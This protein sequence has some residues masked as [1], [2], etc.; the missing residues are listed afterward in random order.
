MNPFY[1][2]V[3]IGALVLLIVV[4]VIVG[5]GMN[6][7]HKQDAFPPVQNACPDYWDVSSNPAYCGAP[8]QSTQRNFGSILIANN[9]IDTTKK[10]NIGLCIAG[11]KNFGCVNQGDRTLLDVKPKEDGK[12]F[13]YVKLN[14]NSAAWNRL[15]PGKSERC[16]QKSWAQ[17]MNVAWDGVSNYNAC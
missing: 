7:L 3:S 8:V 4:L 10:E 1:M 12:H 16:A 17:T 11:D 2:Y 5:V 15:Y 9:Q 14:N 6:S 13:Q